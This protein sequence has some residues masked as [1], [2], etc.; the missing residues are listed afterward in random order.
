MQGFVGRARELSVLSSFMENP[1]IRGLAVYGIRQVGKSELLKHFADGRRSVYVQLDRGSEEAIAESAVSQI[2]AGYEVDGEPRTI[3]GLLDVLG[4]ICYEEPTLVIL[5]EY[6]YMSESAVHADTMMQ[7]FMDGAVKETGS[8]VI[9]CGSQLSSMLDIVEDRGNPLYRRFMMSL[10]VLP[11]SFE[12]TC[13]FH[14]GMDDRDLMRMYMMLGGMPGDHLVFQGRT[15]RDVVANTFL[16]RGMPYRNLARAR[17]GVETGRTDD[18][19]A[20]VRAVARGRVSLKEISRFTG[21]PESTCSG[22]IANLE[23]IGILGHR[24]P[25]AGAPSRKSY[26]IRDGLVGIWYSVFNDMDERTLPDDTDRRFEVLSNRV[27]TYFGHRFEMFCTE[28]MTHSYACT[29]IGTW[30]GVEEDEDGERVGVDID[31]VA[32]V[33]ERGKRGTVYCEC[34]FR[35]RMAKAADLETLR[36]RAERLDRSFNLVFFSAGGFERE[37]VAEASECGAV[38]IGIDELMGRVSAPSLLF[39]ERPDP[40][41]D[42]QALR[43]FRTTIRSC[44]NEHVLW[45][46]SC[47]SSRFSNGSNPS[48]APRWTR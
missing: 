25:M 42:D 31:I 27:E 3:S 48:T 37:M 24:H 13:R 38:L 19:V 18:N 43:R 16:V 8:K 15:F 10:E 5:D 33:V 7:R 44:Y 35:N 11:M 1:G 20:I 40:S 34:K 22:Y 46:R 21:I 6:P 30:W 45:A 23:A 9:I 29:D 2:R 32:D 17:I 28:W 36:R 47:G 14:P 41:D 12:D 4:H 26:L 39:P